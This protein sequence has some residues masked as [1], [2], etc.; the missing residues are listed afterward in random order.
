MKKIILFTVS[1]LL[2]VNS[3]AQQVNEV[4]LTVIGTGVNEEKATLQALRSAIEQSFGTF[5]SANTTILNDK[6]VQD[7]IVSVSNGN[8]KDYKKLSVATMSN[9]QVAVSVQATV[10]INKLISY[11]KSK[12][13]RAEF[14]GQTFDANVK[15]MKL[16]SSSAEKALNLMVQQMDVLSR[17]MFDFEIELGSPIADGSRYKVPYKINVYSNASSS[18]FSTLYTTTCKALE[19]SPEEADQFK[20]E[21]GMHLRSGSLEVLKFVSMPISY[22]TKEN[23]DRKITK[24][25]SKALTRYRIIASNGI[26][27]NDGRKQIKSVL[28]P[29]SQISGVTTHYSAGGG[30]DKEKTVVCYTPSSVKDLDVREYIDGTTCSNSSVYFGWSGLRLPE[31]KEPINLSKSQKKDLKKG[32]YTGPT[33]TIKYGKQKII[34]IIEGFIWVSSSDMGKIQGFELDGVSAPTN[35]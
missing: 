11:A 7:E 34:H 24:I 22:Q 30:P 17:S 6:M 19:I 2:A 26:S 13:S 35:K 31:I 8:V 21:L 18:N 23:I 32:L 9:G 3:L 1:L 14:S 12:G 10:S 29:S 4:T 28:P 25:Y 5:V 16:K 15:L 33:Y 27:I 20:K